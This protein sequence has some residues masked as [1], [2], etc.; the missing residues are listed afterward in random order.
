MNYGLY[1]SASGV[2]SNTYRQDVFANNLANAQTVGFKVDIPSIKQRDTASME[3]QLGYM[4]SKD[5]LDK[6]G[7]GVLAGMQLTQHDRGQFKQTDNPFDMAL[8]EAKTYF[9]VQI[10]DRNG[11]PAIELTRDGRFTRDSQG[12]LATITG[13]HKLLGTDDAP[14]QL[15]A[16]GDILV[17]S[18]GRI[19]VDGEEISRLQITGVKDVNHLIKRG[20]NLYGMPSQDDNFRQIAPR[21]SVMQGFIEQSSVD[22]IKTLMQLTEATKAANSNANMIKYQDQLLDRAINTLGRV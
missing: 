6:L 7:G 8:D 9:A 3:D 12:F 4:F 5:M 21:A 18:D 10:P 17:Q 1:L 22:P 13:G 16:T 2:L 14:I 11:Q 20:Q 19:L 15:P